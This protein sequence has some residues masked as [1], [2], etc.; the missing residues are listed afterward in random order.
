MRAGEG[1]SDHPGTPGCLRAREAGSRVQEGNFTVRKVVAW[2]ED[3]FDGLDGLTHG[4]W[5]W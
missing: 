5:P 3:G 1:V 4:C 2:A